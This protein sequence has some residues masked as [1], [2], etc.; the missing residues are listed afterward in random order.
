MRKIISILVPLL[1]SMATQA[2][3][4]GY[5]TTN[6]DA[7]G[8]VTKYNDS[9]FIYSINGQSESKVA[10]FSSLEKNI[11]D[12]IS[13]GNVISGSAYQNTES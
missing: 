6:F 7:I 12:N 9:L 13:T 8:T 11:F 3:V 1:F 2:T 5:K 10:A 4:M